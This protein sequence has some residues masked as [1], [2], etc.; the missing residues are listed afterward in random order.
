MMRSIATSIYAMYRYIVL[1]IAQKA[2]PLL[3]PYLGGQKKRNVPCPFGIFKNISVVSCP[4]KKK[5]NENCVFFCQTLRIHLL[6]LS[7]SRKF[8]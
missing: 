1:E 7:T 2:P 6:T 8:I 5:V 4:F 3:G